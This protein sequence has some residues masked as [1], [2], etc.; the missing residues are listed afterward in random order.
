[1]RANFID[2]MRR[3]HFIDEMR[4]L[5]F[6]DEMRRLHLHLRVLIVLLVGS[7]ALAG[8][9]PMAAASA[10]AATAATDDGCGGC[11]ENA[12][13]MIPCAAF[14]CPSLPVANLPTQAF[15][16]PPM[17]CSAWFSTA[18]PLSGLT[19]KPEPTPPRTRSI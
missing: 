8:A 6:I 19:A 3:L 17:A 1:V 15:A 7:L 18:R 13:D 14:S 4:R 11:S 12:R 9:M 5:H 10:M 16:V 2:E